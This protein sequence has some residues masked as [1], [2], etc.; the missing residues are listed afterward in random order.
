VATAAL[1]PADIASPIRH[2]LRDQRNCRVVMGKVTDVD[3]A[4]G[5]VVLPGAE[6]EFDWL[7][8]AAGATH[9]YFGQEGWAPLAPGLK[10]LE[11]AV[12]IRNRILLAFECAEYEGSEA[13]RKAALTFAVVGGGPTGVELA[14]AIKEIAAKI[15]PRDFRNIDT[16]TTRVVLLEAGDRLLPQ[17]APDLGDRAR[18][19]LEALGVEVRLGARV[20]QITPQGVA[21]GAEF[22]PV[23]NAFWAAG[24]KANPLG[25][26]LGT[27]LDH[28][29][30]VVVGPDLTVPG[31]PQ[32]FVI[33]DMAAATSAKDSRPVPGVAQG[34]IQMGRHVGRRIAGEFRAGGVRRPFSYRDKGSM[35]TI[36]RWRAVAQIGRAHFGG[37]FAFLLWAVVH[38]A[39][40]INVRNRIAVTAN[41]VWQLVTATRGARLITGDA[42]PCVKVPLA[43]ERVHPTEPVQD[44]LASER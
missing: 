33:G 11:D 29:G 20:T 34:A 28:S 18:R 2:I 37:P 44:T 27:P 26:T 22:L 40:L 32:V 4:R 30:R 23:R 14:G 42:A 38:I 41:W 25:S 5:V 9:S 3:L 10:T 12:A 39:F 21:V 6:V 16:G 7:I 13:E 17:F 31:F 36:G 24:V 43:D 1:S 35:A 19:D 15:I 8:L